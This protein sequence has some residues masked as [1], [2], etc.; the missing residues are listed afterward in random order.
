MIYIL[1]SCKLLS[2]FD[3][4]QVPMNDIIFSFVVYIN[5]YAESYFG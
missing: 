5:T 4:R 2:W 3:A 1:S